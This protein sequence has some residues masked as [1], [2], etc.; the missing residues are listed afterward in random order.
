[1]QIKLR[2]STW[3]VGL[4]FVA[5]YAR[6]VWHFLG[7][8][9]WYFYDLAGHAVSGEHL[10]RFGLHGW[11]DSVFSGMTQGLFYPPL[12]DFIMAALIGLTGAKGT[13]ILPVYMV[14]VLGGFFSAQ[15]ALVLVFRRWETRILATLGLLSL[16]FLDKSNLYTLQGWGQ[17]DL[18]LVGLTSQFLSGI[19]FFLLLRLRVAPESAP[20]RVFTLLVLLCLLSHL[21]TGVVAG[22]LWLDFARERKSSFREWAQEVLWLMG[23]GAFFFLPFWAYRKWMTSSTIY[24]DHNLW[25]LGLFI[26]ISTFAWISRQR[27][28]LVILA[29]LIYSCLFWMPMVDG[30]T[31]APIA[32]HFYRLALPSWVLFWVGCMVVLDRV[33]GSRFSR[34]TWLGM[35]AFVILFFWMGFPFLL[36]EIPEPQVG[37]R[38]SVITYPPEYDS[39]G[40]GRTLVTGRSR[41]CDFGLDYLM[42]ERFPGFRSVKGLNWEGGYTHSIISSYLASLFR[43]PVVLDYLPKPWSNCGEFESLLLSMV[44]L[45]DIEFLMNGAED[46]WA[47]PDDSRRCM[48]GVLM[49]WVQDNRLA[50]VGGVQ[51]GAE[52]KTLYRF[53]GIR[54]SSWMRVG[55]DQVHFPAPTGKYPYFGG[56]V[57]LM[58]EYAIRGQKRVFF[59]LPEDRPVWATIQRAWVG[60]PAPTPVEDD[61]S[62]L[63]QVGAGQYELDLPLEGSGFFLPWTAQPG[64]TLKTA[65]GLELPFVRGLPGVLSHGAGRIRIDF[66]RTPLMWVSYLI[67]IGVWGLWGFRKLNRSHLFSRGRESRI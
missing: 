21:V 9:H 28:G 30:I 13:T 22:L 25:V 59:G 48:L 65:E 55:R 11:N 64:L 39:G 14:A 23:S 3:A 46:Q 2:K 37:R 56:A 6:A 47:M 33:R 35:G 36:K 8:Y 51:I 15:M 27:A 49:N 34:N 38:L 43:G 32:F 31:G 57:D 19:P 50:Q 24:F 4:L 44:E 17:F 45:F 66:G 20:P 42:L 12:E 29:T 62:R 40:G 61:A 26:L 10:L 5:A 16:F 53:S 7:S 18:S 58:M 60:N 52:L 63:R 41:P 54:R 67:S 1:M